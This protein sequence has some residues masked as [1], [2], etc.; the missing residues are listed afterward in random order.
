VVVLRVNAASSTTIKHKQ[1]TRRWIRE[2]KRI[3]IEYMLKTNC[4]KRCL[5]N[6]TVPQRPSEV[7]P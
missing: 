5:V 4:S 3:L 6:L 1:A 2:A 7:L